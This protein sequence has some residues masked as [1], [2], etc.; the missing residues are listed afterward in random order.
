M[1][2]SHGNNTERSSQKPSLLKFLTTFGS[3]WS[4]NGKGSPLFCWVGLTESFSNRPK[5]MIHIVILIAVSCFWGL[6]DWY[7]MKASFTTWIILS[8]IS[9]A[10]AN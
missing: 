6:R 2:S 4:E 1:H 9:K 5:P 3:I 8:A 10:S 7:I